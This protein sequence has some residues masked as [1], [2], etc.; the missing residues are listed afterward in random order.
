MSSLYTHALSVTG[1]MCVCVCVCVCGSVVVRG[2]CAGRC[3]SAVCR[4]RHDGLCLPLLPSSTTWIDLHQWHSPCTRTDHL[5][6]PH[7]WP[8]P[9]TRTHHLSRPHQW[10]SPCTRTHYLIR[11]HQWHSP[12]TRTHHLT[13]PHQWPSPCTRTHHLIRPRSVARRLEARQRPAQSRSTC[14]Q[15]G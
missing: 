5:T 14:G 11:P 10:H 2:Q 9:C 7:Q 6:R 4:R 12:C 13:R 15:V 1:V 8:S 3:L